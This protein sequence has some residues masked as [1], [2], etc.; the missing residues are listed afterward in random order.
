VPEIEPGYSKDSLN[1]YRFHG[2]FS[3]RNY[4][5]YNDH[6][7]RIMDLGEITTQRLCLD[8]LTTNDYEFIRELVNTEGWLRFIGDRNVHTDEDAI[9]YINKINS[10]DN[11]TYWVVRLKE[12]NTPIGII[13]F[14][15]RNYL[16]HFDIGFAFLPKYNGKGYAFEA[17]REV[18]SILSSK[19]EYP[20]I[21]ATTLPANASSINL[22]IKL[23]LGFD[24]EIEVG[25]ERLALYSS[26]AGSR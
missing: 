6:L 9:G 1:S 18:L 17:A 19:P 8:A 4:R 24:K 13:T 5:K 22:L 23:G 7:N 10:A 26:S 3:L 25:N 21:L 16:E 14:I 11:L 2:F 20:V 12:T 15:K